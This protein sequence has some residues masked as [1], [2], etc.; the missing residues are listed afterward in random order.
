MASSESSNAASSCGT[1]EVSFELLPNGKVRFTRNGMDDELAEEILS[2]LTKED[3]QE[4]FKGAESIEVL[5]GDGIMC[6]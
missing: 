6:G 5:L 1:R 4:F 2:T 3:L